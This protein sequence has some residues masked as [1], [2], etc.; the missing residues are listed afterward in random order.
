MGKSFYPGKITKVNLFSFFFICIISFNSLISFTMQEIFTTPIVEVRYMKLKE[1]KSKE[2]KLL[3]K[4]FLLLKWFP[5]IY[6]LTKEVAKCVSFHVNKSTSYVSLR[7][8]QGD[9]HCY[10]IYYWIKAKK[11]NDLF[12][13]NCCLVAEP[14]WNPYLLALGLLAWTD[15]VI[16]FWILIDYL[17]VILKVFTS[18]EN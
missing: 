3:L 9:Y 18:H 1:I 16:E 15:K 10:L 13:N 6:A 11:K 8:L 17:M 7:R 4:C 12:K 2:S 5:E 14:F